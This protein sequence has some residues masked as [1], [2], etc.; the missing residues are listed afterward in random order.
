MIHVE[1]QP[2]PSNFNAKVRVPGQRFLQQ[3]S[4]RILHGTEF[5]KYWK[6]CLNDLR[7]A[8]KG[9]CAYT[10]SYISVDAGHAVGS[11]D[12][13]L[14]KSEAPNLVYEWS[15]Y[16]FCNPKVN[17]NKANSNDVLDPFR[18]Q[19]GWFVIDF[20]TFR[21]NPADTLPGD[22]KKAIQQTIDQLRLNDDNRLA[23]P[24][25]NRVSEYINGE[26]SLDYLRRKYPFIAFELE[27]QNLQETIK[28]RKTSAPRSAR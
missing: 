2:E 5:K 9:I 7:D 13:Y 25:A 28:T 19:N 1:E 15:N 16:R 17:E 24:R 12:H 6:H 23:Q 10:A 3:N 21:V 18:I 8:Y 20:T 22:L 27:R 4:H 26:I 11:V 14:P